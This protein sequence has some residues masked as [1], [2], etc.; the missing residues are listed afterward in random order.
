MKANPVS[1]LYRKGLLML[2][3]IGVLGGFMAACSPKPTPT[4]P[5]ATIVA[6]APPVPTATLRPVAA[7]PTPTQP[8]TVAANPAVPYNRQ[9]TTLT[10][11]HTNDTLGETYPCG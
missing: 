3:L 5:P 2:A 11:W 10:I 1:S 4:L 8:V 7:V 6:P 9:A